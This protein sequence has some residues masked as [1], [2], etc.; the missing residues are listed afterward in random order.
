MARRKK[1]IHVVRDP[2]P[3]PRSLWAYDTAASRTS[4]V[5]SQAGHLPGQQTV[6]LPGAPARALES[7]LHKLSS[8]RAL[9][10]SAHTSVWIRGPDPT[11]L[12]VFW[13]LDL[14]HHCSMESRG[15]VWTNPIHFSPPVP[16]HLTWCWGVERKYLKPDGVHLSAGEAIERGWGWGRGLSFYFS[17][18]FWSFLRPCFGSRLPSSLLSSG[19]NGSLSDHKLQQEISSPLGA[20]IGLRG[21]SRLEAIST[22]ISIILLQ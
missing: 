18:W 4:R 8:K 21:L 17:E 5:R 15:S 22:F 7:Q 16:L 1:R 2:P 6:R 10:P 20:S 14:I 11:K 3:M 13:V 9:L 12:C 19:L